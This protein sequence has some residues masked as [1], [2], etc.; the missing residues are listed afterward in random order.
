MFSLLLRLSPCYC[1]RCGSSHIDPLRR[2]RLERI[3]RIVKAFRCE[4]C[5]KRF[6][7]LDVT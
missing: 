4:E 7:V 1:P 3:V 6:Y 5:W 2:A